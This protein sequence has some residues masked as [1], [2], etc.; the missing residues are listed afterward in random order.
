MTESTTDAA[1][2]EW[3]RPSVTVAAVLGWIAL[4]LQLYLSIRLSVVRGR[5][6]VGGMVTYFSFFTI[7][8]NILASMAL[9]A[10]LVRTRSRVT[11]FFTRPT[12]NTAIAASIVLVAIV[13]TAVL[14]SHWDPK[15]LQLVVDMMLHH[16]MPVMFVTYWWVVVPGEDL[17]WSQVP[18]WA[19][20]PILYFVYA[21]VRGAVTRDY[22]Y[23][24]I[25]AGAL[26]YPHALGN[27]AGILVGFIAVSLIL[28]AVGRVK[29]AVGVVVTPSSSRRAR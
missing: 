24:F 23:P 9:T 6:F 28:V 1:R 26:G 22:P 21:T 18:R 4:A 5:G 13:Y 25:D 3:V 19:S 11:R 17:H 14:Q 10:P 7:L 2:A 20:Y 29:S 8:T 12:V 27:A 15:G 16:L